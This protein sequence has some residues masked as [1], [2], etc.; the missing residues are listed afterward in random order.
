MRQES[1]GQARRGYYKT[2]SSYTTKFSQPIVAGEPL[3]LPS[4][5]GEE[6]K[7]RGQASGVA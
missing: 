3:T 6:G 4:P 5:L 1:K 7:V 2:D